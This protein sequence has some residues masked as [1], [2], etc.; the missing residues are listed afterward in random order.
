M[1][2]EMVALARHHVTEG[3]AIVERQR[4]RVQRLASA[5]RSIEDAD[6]TLRLFESALALFER[7]LHDLA[8]GADHER[9]S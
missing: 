5:G 4:L 6:R 2:D 8:K 1:K 3:R 7:R 9:R